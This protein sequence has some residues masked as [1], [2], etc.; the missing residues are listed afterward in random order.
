MSVPS[1]HSMRSRFPC[2]MRRALL[3]LPTTHTSIISV[4][5]FRVVSVLRPHPVAMPTIMQPRPHCSHLR[6]RAHDDPST[7]T[8]HA[9]SR[10]RSG[11]DTRN[12]WPPCSTRTDGIATAHRYSAHV[13]AHWHRAA[14]RTNAYAYASMMPC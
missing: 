12:A 11:C 8:C 9:F 10:R 4:G 1:R 13:T 7:P 14:T 3:T 6:S 2:P 5:P